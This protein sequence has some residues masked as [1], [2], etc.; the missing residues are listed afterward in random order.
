M[1]R[2]FQVG[3][4]FFDSKVDAKAAR[5]AYTAPKADEK[6]GKFERYVAKGPDHVHFGRY[7]ETP[8]ANAGTRIRRKNAA[9]LAA[10]QATD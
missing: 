3:D 1:K 9:E 10:L 7:D 2:L 4:Q 5:G 8:N 6:I